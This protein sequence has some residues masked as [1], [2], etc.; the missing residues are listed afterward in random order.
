MQGNPIDGVTYGILLLLLIQSLKNELP[1]VAQPLYA[2][3]TGGGGNF[4]GI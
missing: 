4:T 1:K 3:N 2:D